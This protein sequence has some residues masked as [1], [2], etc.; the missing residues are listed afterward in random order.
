MPSI[1]EQGGIDPWP[2][3]ASGQLEPA[4]GVKSV[5][6]Q[7]YRRKDKPVAEPEDDPEDDL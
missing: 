4:V 5:G 7:G 3:P 2:E 1:P 6:L